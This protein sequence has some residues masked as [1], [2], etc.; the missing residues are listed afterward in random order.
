VFIAAP[1]PRQGRAGVARLGAFAAVDAPAGSPQG[2]SIIP[3]SGYQ[4]AE[5]DN[6]N[7]RS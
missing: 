6:A 2:Y 7:T 5:K 1:R 3:P 4:L